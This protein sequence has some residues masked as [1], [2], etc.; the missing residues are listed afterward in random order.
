ML[1][2]RT[3][4]RHFFFWYSLAGGVGAWVLIAAAATLAGWHPGIAAHLLG[5]ALL[6]GITMQGARIYRHDAVGPP[7]FGIRVWRLVTATAFAAMGGAITLGLVT[8]AWVLAQVL[9]S[10]AEARGALVPAAASLFGA[11]FPAIAATAVAVAMATVAHGY[12]GGWRRLVLRQHTVAVP[13]LPLA[14]VG[15]RIVHLSDLH[16]GPLADRAALREAFDRATALD[17][18]LICVT[19]DLA[20]NRYIDLPSW[21]PELARLRARHGVIAILGNHDRRIGA[22]FIAAALATVPGWRL[23]RDE[24]ASVAVGGARLHL[25]GLEDRPRSEAADALPEVLSRV[26][27]GEPAI[28]LVHHPAAFPAI[29]AAQVPLALAGHT[30]AGQVAVPGVPWLNPARLFITRFD[31]GLFVEGGSTLHVSAGL[32]A[33]AQRVRVAVPREIAVLTLVPAVARA[34]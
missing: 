10:R 9:S 2:E 20:D 7:P 17:A 14:L 25:V 23:L 6:I 1:F 30:H 3:V 13:D 16:L 4:F 32:G 12:R 27:A 21:L 34:A 31:G 24:V 19:G 15:F 22:D 26:P 5:P 11:P 33:S 29:V 28:V 8:L 18:D